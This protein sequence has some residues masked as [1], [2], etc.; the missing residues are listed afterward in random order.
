MFI[1]NSLR[2]T[3]SVSLKNSGVKGKSHSQTNVYAKWWRSRNF[4]LKAVKCILCPF[5][6]KYFNMLAHCKVQTCLLPASW[7]LLAWH[8]FQPC[9]QSWYVLSKIIFSFNRLHGTISYRTTLFIIAAVRTSNPTHGIYVCACFVSNYKILVFLQ[10]LAS[11]PL[12]F[13]ESE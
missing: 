7:W 9:R 12:L 13:W 6:G 11:H 4:Y 3:I 10:H 2:R 5:K 8:I 1:T